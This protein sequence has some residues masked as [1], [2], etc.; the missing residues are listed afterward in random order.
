MLSPTAN[1]LNAA[2][3]GGYAIGAFNVYNLEGVR[4]VVEA[5]EAAAS[6]AMLQLHPG[7]LKAGGAVLIALCLSAAQAANV[8]MSVQ[9]DHSSTTTA[10]QH[11]LDAGVRSVMVDGSHLPYIEN[12]A[13]TQ[14]TTA[15]AHTHGAFVEAELGRISGTED[16]LTVEAYQ[17]LLTNPNQAAAFVATTQAD[18]LAVCI[19]NVHGHYS[20]PPQLDLPR[21]EAI[22]V[23]VAVPL[24]LHGASGLPD[25]Q[26]R[27]TI[28]RGVCKLNVNT[29]LRAAYL[30]TLRTHLQQTP[31]LELVPL[32]DAAITAMR[33]VVAEKL[34]L[35]GSVGRA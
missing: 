13:F 9:L 1:L 12:I 33:A 2:Q 3:R 21:L 5:A 27:S 15:L 30:A 29:E 17:S 26:V 18:A 25:A 23:A 11:A 22:R 28:E 31:S 14:S 7:S 35:F 6:P 34:T 16:G 19:G 24:V 4:A 8:P 20:H 32:M 10:I